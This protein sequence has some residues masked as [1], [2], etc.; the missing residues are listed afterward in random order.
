MSDY[1]EN[2][3]PLYAVCVR[4]SGGIFNQED[5]GRNGWLRS[6]SPIN[7]RSGVWAKLRNMGLFAHKP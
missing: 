5:Y 7:W 2:Y 3:A 6:V 4:F 1:R